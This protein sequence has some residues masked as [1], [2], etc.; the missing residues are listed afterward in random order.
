[1]GAWKYI[2][3]FYKRKAPDIGSDARNSCRP[4]DINLEEEIKYDPGLR[5]EIDSYHPNQREGE[6]EIYREWTMPTS[7]VQFSLYI[8]WGKRQSKKVST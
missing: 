5:K 3:R 6:K 1:V 4:D 7:H 8:D 2:E